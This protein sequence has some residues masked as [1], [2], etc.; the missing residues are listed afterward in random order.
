MNWFSKLLELIFGP[1]PQPP[2]VTVYTPPMPQP[3]QPKVDL[4]TLFCE[5]IKRMEGWGVGTTSYKNCNPG[6]L[7][8]GQDKTQWNVLATSANNNFCVFPSPE[9]G[10]QALRNVTVSCAKGTSPHYSAEAKKL[11]L[12]NSGDLNLYQYF[13]IRD[14]ASDGND[15]KALAER[16]GKVLRKDPA[17]FRM[18]QLV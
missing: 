1:F 4:L 7:R 12:S 16:F 18:R 14:P 9:V 8:C 13:L 5:E 11:G 17:L 15:P 6:N 10:M 2:V 3:I